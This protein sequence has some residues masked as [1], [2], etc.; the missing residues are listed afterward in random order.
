MEPQ[1]GNGLVQV[2]DRFSGANASRHRDRLVLALIATYGAN[3][4]EEEVGRP[5]LADPDQS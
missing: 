5:I 4:E 1:N 2:Q 3:D